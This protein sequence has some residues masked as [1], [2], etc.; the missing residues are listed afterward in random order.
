MTMQA[1]GFQEAVEGICASDGRYAPEAY[2][3]LRDALE[4]TFKRR[5]KEG[6]RVSGHVSANELLEGFRRHALHEFGPMTL[7]VLEYWGVRGCEDIGRIVFQLIEAKILG[8]TEDDTI[9]KFREGFDFEE[10]FAS[11]FRVDRQALNA[12]GRMDVR[13]IP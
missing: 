9:D 2:A 3:F 7:T 11:P 12:N 8:K 6:K 4:T 5:K 10:A 1:Q 13:R